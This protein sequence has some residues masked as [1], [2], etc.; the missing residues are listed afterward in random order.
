VSF[1]SSKVSCFSIVALIGV[2][3]DMPALKLLENQRFE[4]RLP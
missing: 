1:E 3:K 2:A 4:I